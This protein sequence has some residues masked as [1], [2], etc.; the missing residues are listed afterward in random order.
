MY[1]NSD[2]IFEKKGIVMKLLQKRLNNGFIDDMFFEKGNYYLIHGNQSVFKKEFQEYLID[3][4]IQYN[5]K[6]LK[7]T[8]ES[9]FIE[10]LSLLD[11]IEF[12]TGNRTINYFNKLCLK[13]LCQKPIQKCNYEERLWLQ[14]LGALNLKVD[15]LIFDHCFNKETNIYH[16]LY[17]WI[18]ECN[19]NIA[20]INFSEEYHFGEKFN[21]IWQVKGERCLF[22]K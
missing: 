15:Y 19:L 14:C 5:N 17:T 3:E 20:I 1:K 13:E 11:N 18:D 8:K 12:L 4:L 21:E 10:K 22:I 7:C 2:K 9:S 16:Q 6:V